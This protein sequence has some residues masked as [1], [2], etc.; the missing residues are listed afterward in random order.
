M[1]TNDVL[2]W[3]NVWLK[4]STVPSSSELFLAPQNCK[5]GF[6]TD[7]FI[8][9]KILSVMKSYSG[10]TVLYYQ[11]VFRHFIRELNCLTAK[12]EQQASTESH[13]C[14]EVTNLLF[15]PVPRAD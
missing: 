1:M 3:P 8:F 6:G 10:Y 11:T 13:D 2:I 15:A 4:Y 7:G 5:A 14:S 12:S 9:V